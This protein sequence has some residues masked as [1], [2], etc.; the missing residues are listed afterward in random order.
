MHVE[1]LVGPESRPDLTARFP[2][3]LTCAKSTQFC[4]TQHRGLPSLR[5]RQRDPEIEL[6]PAAAAERGIEAGDWVTVETPEGSVRAR[7]AFNEFLAPGVACGQHG[8]WEACPQIGAP[9]YD[10]FSSDGANFNLI[11][12]NAAIDPV[13]G[14]VPHRAYLCEIRRLEDASA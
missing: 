11:I 14:S 10:P 6:H 5:R 9:G 2:L 13:S 3:V 4:E 12:G 8:W 7:A 1:P